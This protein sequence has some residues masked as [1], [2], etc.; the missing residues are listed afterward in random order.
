[1]VHLYH[2]HQKEQ[3]CGVTELTEPHIRE[4]NIM[5]K[6]ELGIPVGEMYTARPTAHIPF[7]V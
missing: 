2:P 4:Q 6:S 5:C 7:T 1:L 3:F